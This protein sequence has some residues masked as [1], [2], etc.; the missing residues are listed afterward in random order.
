M[1]RAKT[2]IALN[3]ATGEAKRTDGLTRVPVRVRT[4]SIVAFNCCLEEGFKYGWIAAVQKMCAVRSW[5]P[6]ASP[7]A[8]GRGCGVRCQDPPQHL[9][10][11]AHSKPSRR[12][13]PVI[14]RLSH[15]RHTFKTLQ[16]S[17]C[18]QSSKAG[19]KWCCAP[20][21]IVCCR[22]RPPNERYCAGQ[23]ALASSPVL[24]HLHSKV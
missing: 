9:F 24:P 8:A 6:F 7:P 12:H 10:L 18:Q 5:L 16:N 3:E 4:N 11:M 13:V 17:V 20:D 21:Q 23:L 1:P 19:R 14:S 15:L 22:Q 2:A